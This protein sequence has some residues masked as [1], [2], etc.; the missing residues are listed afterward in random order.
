MTN[1]DK[2]LDKPLWDKIQEQF[3]NS[4]KYFI[5]W[6]DHYKKA[7]GWE[8]LFNE[9]IIVQAPK[10]H[11]LPYEMQHGIWISFASDVLNTLYEQPEY[12]PLLDV[13]EEVNQVFKE[14]EQDVLSLLN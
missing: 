1:L 2:R 13:E 14:I 6:F 11:D 10:F 4:M 9:T 5:Y 8:G 12:T 3:P 7:V